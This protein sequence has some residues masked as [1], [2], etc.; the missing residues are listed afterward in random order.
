MTVRA[1]ALLF[2]L[3]ALLGL[4]AW[5]AK[6]I[7]QRGYD[8]ARAEADAQIQRQKA[9]AAATLAAETEKVRERSRFM[10]AML[11]NQNLK[12]SAHEKT[13]ADMSDR[14]RLAAG[15][16]GRLR[17]PHAAGCGGGGGGTPAGSVGS[18]DGGAADRTEAGG[19]LSVPLTELLQRALREADDINVA[20]A[21]C[22]AD[23]FAVRSVPPP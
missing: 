2:A 7:D 5:T 21:S 22:R 14:L 18:A 9:E 15:P 4:L 20:Y 16:A 23:S 10:N 6:A 13:V 8:R 17:D 11:T 3:A 12:D 1:I 19:L